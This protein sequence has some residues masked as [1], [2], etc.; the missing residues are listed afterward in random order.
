MGSWTSTF[1]GS[2]KYGNAR[3]RS[4]RS[5]GDLLAQ[6]VKNGNAGQFELL[7]TSEGLVIVPTA[8]KNA[9]GEVIPDRSPLEQRIP[10]S[11]RRTAN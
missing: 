10:A 4:R 7:E 2:D 8:R 3:R 11:R 1:L 5:Y 6:H 9:A